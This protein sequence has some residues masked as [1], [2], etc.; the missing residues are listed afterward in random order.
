M[1]IF[2]IYDWRRMLGV[3]LGYLYSRK[4][5]VSQPGIEAV[6]DYLE[7]VMSWLPPMNLSCMN[8]MLSVHVEGDA[9]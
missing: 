3:S 2:N 5:L 4:T 1:G 7:V 8:L 9:E 6:L